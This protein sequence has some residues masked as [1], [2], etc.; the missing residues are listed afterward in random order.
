MQIL[1]KGKTFLAITCP[2][3]K[4]YLA[5]YPE[6]I[7]KNPEDKS[8]YCKCASCWKEIPINSGDIPKEWKND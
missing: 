2:G 8:Y 3:C 7:K 5:V 6:D 4:A 1:S